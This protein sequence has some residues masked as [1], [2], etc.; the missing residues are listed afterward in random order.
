GRA[1]AALGLPEPSAGERVDRLDEL[2][3]QVRAL[4]AGETVSA[5]GRFASLEEAAI[6][7][8]P[9]PVPI[10]VSAASP[11]ALAVLRRHADVW[12]ANVPPI[13]A[14]LAPLRDALGRS[15][16]T[17]LWIFARPGAARDD[18]LRAYRR[19]AP[20]FRTLAD[21]DAA[22]AILWGEPARCRERLD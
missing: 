12:D 14:R 15:L 2:L 21:A 20:W 17:W 7:P 6:T 5:R 22:D 16:P 18:A 10:A 8:P 11:P 9:V 1:T 3:G 19:H 4:L 13:R